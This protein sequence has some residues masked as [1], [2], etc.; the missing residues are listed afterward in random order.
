MIKDVRT[1]P[2]ADC[3]SDHV[4]VVADIVLKLKKVVRKKREERRELKQLITNVQLKEVYRVEVENRYEVLNSEEPLEGEEEMD[5][6]WRHIKTALTETAK[7]KVPKQERRGRQRWITEEILDKMEEKRTQKER[8]PQRYE[9]LELEIRQA[10]DGAKEEWIKEQC[11]EVEELERQHKFE[12]MHKKIK[13][14]IGKKRVA[15]GNVI[16]NKEGV[17]VMKIEDVLKRWEEHVKDLFEDNRGE[18]PRLHIPMTGP[19]L[20]DEEI[21]SVIKS[22][23]KGKSPGNDE[24]T[25][26]MILA[27]GEF[28]MRK[29]AELARKIYETGYIPK[30]MYK[31]IFITIPKKPGAVECNLFRTIS[32][33]S[34]ITKIILKVILN[35]I[36]Q[37][38]KPEIAEEQ[39]GFVKGKGTRNAI[40]ILRMLTESSIE[41]QKD[42]Y[43]C[44]IDYE[45]AFDRVRHTD[46]ID[47]LQRINLDGKDIRLITNLYWS[48]LAAVNIDN[49]L[50][51][52]IEIKRGV[53]QGCVLSPDLFSIY[54]EII[55]RN[56]IGMEGI[57]I[58]GVNINNIRYADDS[59]Y[60]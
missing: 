22:F 15:K 2:G 57:S 17:I 4:P 11:R 21:I 47:I 51:S 42:V 27:S 35:R 14:V 56:I 1:Y 8:N 29:I 26:E 52:W 28:G 41:M 30:E 46:L 54:G 50:T 24:V 60:C 10:C 39:Y 40:F 9:E 45:K 43:M 36:K 3:Y 7:E 18:R 44:F 16:K 31:S 48:Q 19:E 5:R 37:K 13:E 32:L 34:Q 12:A 49:N 55:M 20:L 53:R 23:K 38:L 58:G 25:I 33:M 6:D 59:D